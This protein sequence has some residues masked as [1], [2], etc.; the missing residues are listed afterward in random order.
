MTVREAAEAL[1]T[2]LEAVPKLQVYR[3]PG[4]NVDPPAAVLGPPSLAWE[5]YGDGTGV[6]PTSATFP[7]YVVTAADDRSLERLW[8]LVPEV[9]A[10]LE[11]VADAVT[12]TAD[13]GAYNTG[14]VQLPC[15]EILAEVSL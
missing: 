3:D 2:A 5:T 10:A 1:E 9:A 7:V 14:G 8:E 15:Y 11:S 12:P 4:A 6:Y 13:P